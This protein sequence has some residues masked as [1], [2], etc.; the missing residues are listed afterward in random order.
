MKTWRYVACGRHARVKM[1]FSLAVLVASES[2]WTRL[3][4]GLLAARDK[5]DFSPAVW[6]H[7]RQNERKNQRKLNRRLCCVRQ[8][9]K[10]VV[11]R[12]WSCQFVFR[13]GALCGKW[14]EWKTGCSRKNFMKLP[15]ILGKSA[16]ASPK[17]NDFLQNKRRVGGKMLRLRVSWLLYEAT[18]NG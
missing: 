12:P 14:M 1:A 16:V 3:R 7:R 9:E 17:S 15:F 10:F 11:Y 8:S 5:M 6:L 18:Q 4:N 2:K 13:T